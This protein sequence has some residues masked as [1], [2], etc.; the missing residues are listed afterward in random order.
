MPRD[1]GLPKKSKVRAA[2][3]R[4]FETAIR[5]GTKK[6]IDSREMRDEY[7]EAML[8]LIEKKQ[9]SRKDIV[10]TGERT[11]KRK[12]AE[13]IDLMEVLKR[14]LKQGGKSAKAA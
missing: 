12:P 9:T 14:S 3:V 1:V 7:A 13:V 6:T 2:S 4:K 5:R 11:T 8:K 10:K